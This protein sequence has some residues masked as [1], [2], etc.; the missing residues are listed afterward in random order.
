MAQ[1]L[2][3]IDLEPYLAQWYVHEQGGGDPVRITRGSVEAAIL[4]SFLQQMPEG[5]RV[6]PRQPGQLAIAIPD[7]KVK[8]PQLYCYLPPRA[9]NLLVTTIRNR[10][11]L[12]MWTTLH[13]F[14]SVF[15][16][17]DNL[18]YAFME[19]HGIE[20]TETNWNAIAKRYQRKR[21]YYLAYERR[22]RMNKKLSDSDR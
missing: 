17:Q 6:Q 21:K 8:P 19:K 22:K 10:F 2:L 12:A 18:I 7:S 11:D 5:H 20:P 9:L 15:H 13:R 1:I 16:R 3:Y 14:S 4:E